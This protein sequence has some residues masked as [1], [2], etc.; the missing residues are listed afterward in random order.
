MLASVD[1]RQLA[2]H[3]QFEADL[4]LRR[5]HV[6]RRPGAFGSHAWRSWW[7]RHRPTVGTAVLSGLAL[8]LAAVDL[9]TTR[10]VPREA[11]VVRGPPDVR[12]VLDGDTFTAGG[13][14]IRLRGCLSVTLDLRAGGLACER[15]CSVS[16]RPFIASALRTAR[17]RPRT[18]TCCW[19]QPGSGAAWQML[20]DQLRV[21]LSRMS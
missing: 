17:R 18:N 4:R 5:A 20:L 21:L 11:I 15:V 7:R 16:R 8:G 3:R 9:P 14:S 2:Q 6:A 19:K 1:R 12:S 13:T 10:S